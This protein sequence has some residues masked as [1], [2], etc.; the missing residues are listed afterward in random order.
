MEILSVN[1]LNTHCPAQKMTIFRPDSELLGKAEYGLVR[2][3]TGV[4]IGGSKSQ[5]PK[6]YTTLTGISI[7]TDISQYSHKKHAEHQHCAGFRVLAVKT[8]WSV[9]SCQ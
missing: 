7:H 3:H 9:R 8:E 2:A 6:D 4:R 1:T 5:Y